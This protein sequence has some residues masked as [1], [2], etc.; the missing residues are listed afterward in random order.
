MFGQKKAEP[1]NENPLPSL[2]TKLSKV[3]LAKLEKKRV[4]MEKAKKEEAK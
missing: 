4:A 2:K 3:M 1:D